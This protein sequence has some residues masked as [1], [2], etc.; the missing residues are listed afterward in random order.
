MEHL[1]I[2]TLDNQP[3]ILFW[4]IEEFLIMAIPPF[5]GLLLGNLWVMLGG[6]AL[7][8]LYNR[9]R[10]KL[11]RGAIRHRLYWHLPKS[12]FKGAGILRNLPP[13]HIRELLL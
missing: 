3:R 10:R 13:S 7:K 6:F 1:V 12:A 8:P 9:L 2:K 5:I 4:G 11:P